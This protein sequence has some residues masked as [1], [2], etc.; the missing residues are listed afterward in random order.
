MI[1]IYSTPNCA[2]CNTLKQVYNAHEVE[3]EEQQI[4]FDITKEQL[5]QMA[6]Q[7]IRSAPVVFRGGSY[8]GGFA[9]GMQIMNAKKEEAAKAALSHELK[10]LGIDLL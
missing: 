7:P 6:G 10:A 4:G 8:I 1:T 9:E 2:M 5:E 3:Y